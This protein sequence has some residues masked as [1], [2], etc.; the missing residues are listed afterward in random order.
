M[1]DIFFCGDTHGELEHIV[2][3]VLKHR[4]VAVI[5]VGDLQARRP[6]E[7]ELAPIL[8]MTEWYWI[9]GNHDSDSQADVNHSFGSGLADRNIHGRVVQVAGLR[10]A[11]LGGV[12]RQKEIWGPPRRFRHEAEHM[13]DS[14]FDSYEDYVQALKRKSPPR[15]WS[16]DPAALKRVRKH[17]TSIFPATWTAL[18]KLRANILVAHEAP[19]AHPHG[20]Q[21]IDLLAQKMHATVVAHG[22]H[23]DALDYSAR[24]S[25][26]G[27]RTIGVGLRGITALDGTVIRPGELDHQRS[28]RAREET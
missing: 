8:G 22:H 15:T 7:V 21:S 23:H 6:L 16:D 25:A 17:R 27:F 3:A 13:A 24:T 5:S 28:A 18:S 19:S 11:G 20:F 4:P 9:P 1:R 14:K 2:Q 26:D 10:V 12:F